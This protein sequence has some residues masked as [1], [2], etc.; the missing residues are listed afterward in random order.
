MHGVP[1]QPAPHLYLLLQSALKVHS[2]LTRSAMMGR[3]IDRHLLG[4]R[5]ILSDE[6]AWLDDTSSDVGQD[7]SSQDTITPGKA[8]SQPVSASG[9]SVP[10]FED[11]IFKKSQ[12]W[13]LSTSGLSEGWWFRGTG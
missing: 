4:L 9:T 13:R 5:C 10:L 11:A 7:T 2:S 6:W 3:G 1:P 12:E 8:T